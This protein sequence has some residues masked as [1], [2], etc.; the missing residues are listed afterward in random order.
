MK[1]SLDRWLT[2]DPYETQQ[3]ELEHNEEQKEIEGDK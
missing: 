1:S 2:K 3:A